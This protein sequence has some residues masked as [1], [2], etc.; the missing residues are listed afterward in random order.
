MSKLIAN[1][2]REEAGLYAGF[3]TFDLPWSE[4]IGR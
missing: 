3:F 4:S 1:W 2:Q